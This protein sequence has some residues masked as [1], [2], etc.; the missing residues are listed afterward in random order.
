MITIAK[1]IALAIS[2]VGAIGCIVLGAIVTI[3]LYVSLFTGVK[4]R[5]GKDNPDR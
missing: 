2:W 1:N 3:N 4:P 5:G